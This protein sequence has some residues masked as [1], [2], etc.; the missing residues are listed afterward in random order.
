MV[1]VGGDLESHFAATKLQYYIII[2]I[3]IQA[4]LNSTN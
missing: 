4:L 1:Q 2:I 3:A